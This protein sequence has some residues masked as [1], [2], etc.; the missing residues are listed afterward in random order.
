MIDAVT[1]LNDNAMDDCF[2]AVADMSEE[3]IVNSLLCAKTVVGRTGRPTYCLKDAAR[4]C[5]ISL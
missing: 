2:A 1:R 4:L 3:A 5:G